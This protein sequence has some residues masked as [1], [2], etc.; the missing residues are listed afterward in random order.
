MEPKTNITHE[1]LLER[2]R[3][4]PHTG[5][6]VFRT[7]RCSNLIGRVAG[8]VM[9]T[10]YVEVQVDKKRF[11]AHRL[12]WF[13]MKGAWPK[14]NLDHHDGDRSNNR[15]SNLREA[16]Q[17]QNTCNKAIQRN[18]RSGVLG[19]IW[20][21]ARGLWRAYVNK[22]G[23]HYHLGR[24]VSLDDAIAARKEGALAVHGVFASENRP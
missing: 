13:Y 14:S 19:V 16:T 9:S 20:D 1:R 24:F 5:D 2:L 17:A 4:D 3:Y 7:H 22:N 15:F 23:Q 8:S 6:F 21:E 10:G 12:A 11:L 18:N